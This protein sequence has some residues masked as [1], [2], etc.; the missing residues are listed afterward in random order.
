MHSI[1]PSGTMELLERWL[2]RVASAESMQWL[3]TEAERQRFLPDERRLGV[4]LGL[5]PRR[6]GRADLNLS[7]D[8]ILA[9][10]VLRPRWRPDTWST[11]QAARI[12]LVLSTWRQDASAFAA[13]LDRTCE[14]ADLGELVACLKGFAIFPASERL[15]ARAREALRS[16]VQPVFEAIA[17]NNPYPADHLEEP[18]Y[19]QMVVKCIFTGVSIAEIVGLDERRN[20]DLLGMLGA[21][22]SERQAAGR[23]VP[24][25]V[26]QWIADDGG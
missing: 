6:I 14:R 20:G 3:R 5:C 4:A 1:H 21:L 9:A 26:L 19:N 2:A 18:A 13:L 12:S 17:C 16:S 25:T 24:D 8:D 11:D 7:A 15:Y 22:V 10:Q 23:M